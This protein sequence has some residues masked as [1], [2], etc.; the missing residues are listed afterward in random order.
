[1][2]SMHSPGPQ[3]ETIREPSSSRASSVSDV[4]AATPG[5]IDF[6]T[7]GLD[8]SSSAVRKR[9]GD[10]DAGDVMAKRSKP[11][12]AE[13]RVASPAN[14]ASKSPSA[15]GMRKHTKS[16]LS[17][18]LSG[19]SSNQQI[20]R[21][22]RLSLPTPQLL[23][24][25]GGASNDA[26]KSSA[27]TTRLASV[28][29]ELNS[30]NA[31]RRVSLDDYFSVSGAKDGKPKT[32]SYRRMTIGSTSTATSQN[33]I[34]ISSDEDETPKHALKKPPS[35][36]I[37]N[38]PQCRQAV[39]KRAIAPLG[40]KNAHI[41]TSKPSDTSQP[42]PREVIEL[43]NTSDSEGSDS[44]SSSSVKITSV[45]LA[46]QRP[47]LARKRTGGKRRSPLDR[48]ALRSDAP[49]RTGGMD[50]EDPS[51][52]SAED[53]M[54]IDESEETTRTNSRNPWK[55]FSANRR[56]SGDG[57]TD[58][59]TSKSGD[60][61]MTGLQDALGAIP[62]SSKQQAVGQIKSKSKQLP[63]SSS[64]SNQQKDS[65]GSTSNASKLSTRGP[66]PILTQARRSDLQSLAEAINKAG[67][68]N[69]THE[70][71]T[72]KRK[73]SRITSREVTQSR[74]SS[75]SDGDE[76]NIGSSTT[77]RVTSVTSKTTFSSGRQHSS[78]ALRAR[79]NLGIKPGYSREQGNTTPATQRSDGDDNAS[80]GSARQLTT[81][82]PPD[83]VLVDKGK[84][85]V[86]EGS[87]GTSSSF[88]RASQPE[89]GGDTRAHSDAEMSDPGAFED[90]MSDPQGVLVPE[91]DEEYTEADS[92]NR[93]SADDGDADQSLRPRHTRK[94]LPKGSYIVPPPDELNSLASPPDSTR[95]T[96]SFIADDTPLL[97]S[98]EFGGYTSI[99]FMDHRRAILASPPKYHRSAD[100]PHALQDQMNWMIENNPYNLRGTRHVFE[101]A[102]FENTMEDEP[103]APAIEIIND[104]DTEVTPP[105]EFYYSNKMWHAEGVPP[106]D[107]AGL[108]GCDCVGRCD[109]RSKT[110]KCLQ[111]QREFSGEISPDFAYDARGKLKTPDYPIFEC[112]TLCGC[113]ED[114]RNRVVQH[115]R[116]VALC[117]KK[118]EFKGW[119]VF[120]MKKILAGSFIG[121]YAGEILTDAQGEERGK[122]YDSIGRTYLF[123]IDFHHL[124]EGTNWDTKYVVDAYHAG[125]FTRFL[126]HSCDPNSALYPCYIDE[127]NIDKPLL[128]IF[129]TRDIEADEEI[130][131]SYFGDVDAEDDS[132]EGEIYVLSPPPGSDAAMTTVMSGK[133][134]TTTM[135]VTKKKSGYGRCNCGARN[136]TGK[137]F[138]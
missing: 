125:N 131:F 77:S 48:H 78:A 65:L 94:A 129:A 14:D 132:D 69:V 130:C 86:K 101:A 9:K 92:P 66:N 8:K 83:G 68:Q 5:T 4:T 98:R 41:S 138:F 19:P 58:D 81:E 116:Q 7:R 112:N 18:P 109:P 1:M 96:P 45:K 79:R 76:L 119:G 124:R 57:A 43:P 104:V 38:P 128:A 21:G 16:S 85:K 10:A 133:S 62:G 24:P 73:S 75:T 110:C 74:A 31:L 29:K 44:S 95:S 107:I 64:K 103:E 30:P 59:A 28:K 105:W 61:D 106:P 39:S 26:S 120:A 15:N 111:R 89:A 33:P 93:T 27:T 136:C 17:P 87:E 135:T 32:A 122:I 12:S 52:S 34:V 99:T 54:D 50:G 56:K 71:A 3:W 126:N 40:K 53:E 36:I 108:V 37:P 88:T 91:S 35:S 123:D 20:A 72:M 84:R 70:Q 55:A 2:P 22:S 137:F 90:R 80:S 115:G 134:M 23:S 42:T 6:P 63:L 60:I 46:P 117:I 47:Q 114:C 49:V 51:S 25:T 82:Q 11:L 100:L 127:G 121:I 102:I 118:T 113:S 13:E 67:K 97:T